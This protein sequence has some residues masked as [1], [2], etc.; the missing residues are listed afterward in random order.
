MWLYESDP[1]TPVHASN[2]VANIGNTA[3][4]VDVI[5]FHMILRIKMAQAVEI[6]RGARQTFIIW[7]LMTWRRDEPGHQHQCFSLPGWSGNDTA[8][9][10]RHFAQEPMV[11][12]VIF[13]NKDSNAINLMNMS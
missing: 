8:R 10:I 12:T 3:Y 13:P 2:Q 6:H 7:V 1:N 5:A 4:G 11:V 9:V